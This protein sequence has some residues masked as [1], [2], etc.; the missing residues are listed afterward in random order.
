[1]FAHAST[2]SAQTSKAL[3]SG[4]ITNSL[5]GDPVKAATVTCTGPATNTHLTGTTNADGFRAAST[6]EPSG[7]HSAARS[8]DARRT[9]PAEFLWSGRRPQLLDTYSPNPGDP[10]KLEASISDAV[11]P[12]DIQTLPLEGNNINSILLFEPGTTA[13]N[14]TTR[15]QSRSTSSIPRTSSC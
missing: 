14:A 4:R 13:S 6:D 8:H 2:A 5:S 12:A 9:F 7:A 3:I 15:S 10:G 11:Q 1:L